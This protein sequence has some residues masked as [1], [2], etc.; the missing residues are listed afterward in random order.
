MVERTTEESLAEITRGIEEKDK[1]CQRYQEE[2]DKYDQ[3]Y[4]PRYNKPPHPLCKK[5]EGCKN[6]PIERARL[7]LYE[8]YNKTLD[9][10]EN[11]RAEESAYSE[12]KMR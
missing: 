3:Q 8:L 2:N 7:Q 11:V 5:E 10:M 9:S 1:I 12:G 6:C 4:L